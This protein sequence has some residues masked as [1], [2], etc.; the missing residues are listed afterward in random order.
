Q[1]FATSASR[2]SS[3]SAENVGARVCRLAAL[4]L[5]RLCDMLLDVL[6]LRC[7]TAL[8][9]AECFGAAVTG[10][11]VEAGLR[12]HKQRAACGLLQPEFDESGRLLRIIYFGIDGISMPGEG[13]RPFG[14]D[15]LHD[16]LP[17]H[18]LVAGM[19]NL[20]ARDLTRYEWALQLYTKPLAKLAVICQR[21][22]DPRNRGL[23]IHALFDPVIHFKQPPGCILT[24]GG[25][26]GNPMVA[27]SNRPLTSIELGSLRPP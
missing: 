8:I 25:P 19:G 26:Q 3:P 7:P 27:V 12:E 22:P 20:A 17:S 5:R 1:S 18:V 2:V 9:H 14:L 23:Q 16:R 24:W 15:F 10:D 6:H 4:R 11:L 13:E 21:P